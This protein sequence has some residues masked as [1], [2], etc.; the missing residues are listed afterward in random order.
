MKKPYSD[1]YKS[2]FEFAGVGIAQVSTEGEWLNVNYELCSML[3]YSKEELLSKTFQDVTYHED[4]DKDLGTLSKMLKKEISY[5]STQKRYYRKDGTLVWINLTTNLVLDDGGEPD[6]FVSI[7]EDISN[8]ISI[9]DESLKLKKYLHD[10]ETLLSNVINEIPDVLVLKDKDGKFLLGNKVVAELYGTTPKDMIGKYDSDFGVPKKISDAMKSSVMSVMKN[11]KTEI[12]YED[13]IDAKTGEVRHFKSIKKPFKNVNG[14]DQV[15]VIAHD[16]TDIIETQ[17][18]LENSESKLEDILEVVGE[19][20]W[21]WDMLNNNVT[22]NNKWCELL[23]VSGEHKKHKLDF[24]VS[25]IYTEHKEQVFKRLQYAIEN[26]EEYFSHHKLV[27]DDGSMFWVEDRGKIIQRDE[28]NNP[29]MMVGAIR[30]ITAEKELEQYSMDIKEALNELRK[31]EQELN[32]YVKSSTDFVWEV[33][34]D[35]LFIKI[36]DGFVDILG[37]TK[38]EVLKMTPFDIMTKDEAKRVKS[39]F[40]ELVKE[41]KPIK[42]LENWV[43]AKDGTRHCM[44]T[45]GVPFYSEDGLFIGYRG[46]DRDITELTSIKEELNKHINYDNLTGLPNRTLFEDRLESSIM[47]AKRDK[48]K[49]AVILIDMD[50]LKRINDSFSHEAGDFAIKEFANWI[51]KTIR[52]EDTISRFSGDAFIILLEDIKDDLAPV[53][54]LESLREI[55]DSSYVQIADHELHLTFSAGISLYPEDGDNASVILKNA[56]AAMYEAKEEGRN[57]YRYYKDS[58]TERAFERVIIQS[59]LKDAIKNDEFKLFYQPQYNVIDDTLIGMEAL[60]RWQHS[61]MGVVLPGKFIHILE[62]SN[63]IIEVGEWVLKTAFIQCVQWHSKGL[64]PGVVSINLAIPQLKTGDEL[65]KYIKLLLEETKCKA[66]WIG[67]EVTESSDM[68]SNTIVIDTLKKL[69]DMGFIISLDDFGTGYSSLSY[70]SK[71]P[72]DKLKIDKSFIDNILEN[73]NDAALTKAIVAMAK[74][75]NLGVI[76]EGVEDEAQKDYLVSIGCNEIQGYL[77][78]KPMPKEKV[79]K[80]LG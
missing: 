77:Y 18:A 39:I 63:L 70:L 9:R 29:T 41:Q 6:F 69:S 23:G 67:L 56:D 74:N 53:R 11:N 31:K 80:I 47:R 45:N 62:S 71:L 22:H 13:S 64:K 10:N 33:N 2:I 48:E 17:K 55:T 75:L 35:G 37:Y 30:D 46:T 44:I 26:N 78:A 3:Q 14:D 65:V 5:Y 72:L 25:K 76:A 40:D 19:G 43:I 36:S 20:V 24:F 51:A 12:V 60:I 32:D 8:E 21:Q 4:L 59:S 54:L 68:E 27:R 7:I 79:D 57:T 42:D 34:A 61:S 1:P 58:M 52:D 28:E 66:E 38:E 50:H 15:L 73:K 16:V 49:L